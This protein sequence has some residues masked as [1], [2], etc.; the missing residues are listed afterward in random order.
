[1]VLIAVS[2]VTWVPAMA[3]SDA[4]SPGDASD[5]SS[6]SEPAGES[7]SVD[8]SDSSDVSGVP[9]VEAKSAIILCGDTGEII[10]EKNADEKME[11][12]SMT[13]LMT[14][15]LAVE[16]L[17]PDQEVEVTG[18]AAA[19]PETKIYLQTGEKI[20]VEELLY[21]LLLE[22]GN[23]AAIALAIAT[24]GSV[25]DFAAMMNERAKEIGCTNTN[26]VNPSGLADENHYSTARDMVM[27]AKEALSNETVRK[28]AGT[29]EH[30][31][32][33]TNAYEERNLENTNYFLKGVDKEVNGKKIKVDKYDGVFGGKTGYVGED[34]AALV[35]GL[36]ADG[37]EIYS[38]VMGSSLEGRY[39]D[40]KELMDYG[41]AN[42][43]KYTVFEKGDEFGKVKLLGGA[44]N[45]VK[46][47]AADN[48]YINL[49]EGVSASLVTTEC[50]YTDSLFAP[51]KKG[52]KIGV[53]EVYIA[54][55]L[56]KTVELVAAEDIKEGWF[57]S[58]IG[59]SNFQTVMIGVFLAVILIGFVT[60]ISMR[61]RNKRKLARIRRRKL[62][63][64]ALRQ[65]E[66]EEDL[67][68][69]GWRF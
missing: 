13:K 22:S 52:Q 27:I 40:V 11:P 23:D 46:A 48:G 28:I 68:R 56:K 54:G 1:M 45:K 31:I 16:N 24:A 69:R 42:V 62:E 35:T 17:K 50:V 41:K 61:I 12:A 66:R 58:G 8:E 37:L 38:L 65:L 6:A 67:K 63:E 14:A 30:T 57:L 47:V 7:N 19:M 18:E 36:S 26:F 49:P 15:L 32:P 20:T 10:W 4:V 39:S 9:D 64:E 34:K 3:V 43:S 60:I 53:V 2:C 25:E 5:S 44:V 21:G 51:V 55:E 33:A 29:A 59:I